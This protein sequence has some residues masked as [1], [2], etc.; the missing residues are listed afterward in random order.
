[1]PPDSSDPVLRL[2][3][4]NVG[5]GA[6]AFVIAEIGVNHDGS[7]TRAL[8]LVGHARDAGAD[9]IKLQLFSAG[10]LVHPCAGLADYQR[11]AG[12]T[13]QTAMLRRFELAA[14]EVQRIV[15]AARDAGLVPLATPFS[16]E[17]LEQI[18]RLDLPAIKLA[19]PDLVNPLLLDAAADSGRAI[20]ASTGAA[21]EAE[22]I[23]AADRLRGR[24]APFALLHCVSSYPTPD[25]AAQLRRVDT[26][27]RTGEWVVGLSDHTQSEL[28]GALAVAAG[29]SVIEKHL[30]HD[31][32]AAGPDHAASA[33]PLMFRRYVEAIRQAEV[34]LGDGR[35]ER[36]PQA[37]E[38]DVRRESRQSLV[39]RV[40]ISAG[41]TIARWMLTCQRPGTGLPAA[42]LD[43]V[44]GQ[45]TARPLLAGAM[46]QSD[47]LVRRE[48]A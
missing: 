6:P 14:G 22:I 39:A 11:T 32:R 21:D 18:E 31:R 44:I 35:G 33:D 37:C 27:R 16:P 36:V 19:S 30:T 2:G 7:V 28:A 10:R 8:E 13:D 20:L 26:L 38:A 40:D 4:R 24:H 9:A 29:A 12:E 5:I 47:D 48:A 23:W 42:M 45:R 34:L 17:D 41:A 3:D 1:M 43:A 15:D 25:P 46:L